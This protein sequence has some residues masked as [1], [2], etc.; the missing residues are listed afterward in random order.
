MRKLSIA[1]FVAF[2][3]LILSSCTQYILADEDWFGTG[4]GGV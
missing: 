4:G 1:A 3:A 2:I